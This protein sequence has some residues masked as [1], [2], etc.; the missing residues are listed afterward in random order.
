VEPLLEAIDK[1]YLYYQN[2]NVDIIKDGISVPCLTLKYMKYIF[3]DLQDY[4]TI[5]NEKN[6]DLYQL[7]KNT[8]TGGPSIVFV[9][10][11]VL[12][13]ELF[14]GGHVVFFPCFLAQL[15]LLH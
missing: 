9:F 11:V 6:K 14:H 2:Q 7:Y 12:C 8:I 5:P 15:V 1:M 10:V 3:Q 4:F 13:Q